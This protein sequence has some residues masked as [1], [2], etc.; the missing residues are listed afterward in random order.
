MWQC[1]NWKC[2][3][4]RNAICANYFTECIDWKCAESRNAI[5]ANYFAVC[6]GGKSAE[7]DY[8]NMKN[9]ICFAPSLYSW[10]TSLSCIHCISYLWM[11]NT[12][13]FEILYSYIIIME[14]CLILL[15]FD[16]GMY[17]LYMYFDSVSFHLK[18]KHNYYSKE[19]FG[20]LFN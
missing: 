2:A 7:C 17:I 6:V 11:R 3:F 10:A 12:F 5:C 19:V 15:H 9:Q 16:K 4:S 1:V 13:I 20:R 8:L 14:S 18:I